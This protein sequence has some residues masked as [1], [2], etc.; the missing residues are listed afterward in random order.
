MW[1]CKECG[2]EVVYARKTTEVSHVSK[3]GKVFHDNLKIRKSVE[4]VF[5]CISNPEH[6]SFKIDDIASWE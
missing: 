5:T 2:S 4:N 3:S 1:K 6:S